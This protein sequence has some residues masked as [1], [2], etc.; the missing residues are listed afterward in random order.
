V[1]K[2]DILAYIHYNN[3]EKLEASKIRLE[4]CYTIV[5]KKVDKNKLI[6][7]VVTKDGICKI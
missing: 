6:Y 7:G 5:D 3:K 2:G 1:N 4:G